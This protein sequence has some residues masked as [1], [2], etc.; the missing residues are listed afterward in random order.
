VLATL[1]RRVV[2]LTG[3][4]ASFREASVQ[5]KHPYDLLVIAPARFGGRNF[6]RAR[7]SIGA[8]GPSTPFVYSQANGQTAFRMTILD[9]SNPWTLDDKHSCTVSGLWMRF[10]VNPARNHGL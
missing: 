6:Q 9:F 10:P 3:G 1:T 8:R 4:F 2:I 5:S 7:T